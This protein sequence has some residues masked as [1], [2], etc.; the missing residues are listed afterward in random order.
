MHPSRLSA[1][2]A[3]NARKFTSKMERWSQTI[4]DFEARMPRPKWAVLRDEIGVDYQTLVKMRRAL[5]LS[6]QARR[7]RSE[8]GN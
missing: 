5:G 6:V 8:S 1:V 2:L 7:P 4:L 3:A